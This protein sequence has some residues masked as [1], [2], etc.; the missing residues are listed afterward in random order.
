MT[1]KTLPIT[2]GCLCGD[3]R[4][5]A[6]EPP[7]EG[8][9]CHCRKCQQRTGNLFY[10]YVAFRADVLQITKG[11]PKYF[12]SSDWVE[13]SF[14]ANCGTHLT[15]RYLE[16]N[17][18]GIVSTGSLDDPEAWPP[19]MHVG[20]EGQLSWLNIHDDLPRTRTEDESTYLTAKA[21]AE[22]RSD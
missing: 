9:Y 5:Q 6:T 2:G 21:A 15:V 16:A 3:V 22:S 4:Y 8:G 10:P 11:K 19:D 18:Q 12:R 1:D 7:E 13:Y 20:V 14:C 17:T